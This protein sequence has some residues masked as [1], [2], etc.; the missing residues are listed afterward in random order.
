MI[1]QSILARNGGRSNSLMTASVHDSSL[2]TTLPVALTMRFSLS[3]SLP[4]IKLALAAGFVGRK[5]FFSAVWAM[6]CCCS[7]R[8]TA[9]KELALSV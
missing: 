4:E 8:G 9:D 7:L 2:A 6:R 1:G 3:L 5:L